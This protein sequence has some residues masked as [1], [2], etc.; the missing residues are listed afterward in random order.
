MTARLKLEISNLQEQQRWLRARSLA[1]HIAVLHC[2]GL[3]AAAATV[4]QARGATQP[5][6]HHHH[7][8]HCSPPSPAAAAAAAA[9]HCGSS[10]LTGAGYYPADSAA[11]ALTSEGT[12]LPPAWHEQLTN[13]KRQ[14]SNSSTATW[15]TRQLLHSSSGGS[16]TGG[17]LQTAAAALMAPAMSGSLAADAEGTIPLEGMPHVGL[18]WRPAAAAEVLLGADWTGGGGVGA[19]DVR[20]RLLDYLHRSAPYVA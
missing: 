5:A 9:L 14:L 13:L 6:Y 10:I 18:G 16:T 20:A 15:A 11:D 19:G 7:H 8:R 17:E 3:V 12:R 4:A 2:E 1:T